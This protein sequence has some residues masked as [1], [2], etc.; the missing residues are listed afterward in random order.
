M[1]EYTLR[2]QA[3]IRSNLH[4]STLTSQVHMDPEE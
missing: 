1:M 2:K 3:L 4:G